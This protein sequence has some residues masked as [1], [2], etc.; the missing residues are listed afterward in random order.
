MIYLPENDPRLPTILERGQGRTLVSLE[1]RA[2]GRDLLVLITGGQAHVGAVAVCHPS[3]DHARTDIFNT[4]VVPGHKEGPL[5]GDVAKVL[6]RVTG[7]TCVACVGIHQDQASEPEIKAIV[8]NV[9]Q[10][11]GAAVR[12]LES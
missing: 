6:A 5:A 12:L 8:A 10:A 11:L 2:Q 3:P 4:I 9:D 1:L 7:C